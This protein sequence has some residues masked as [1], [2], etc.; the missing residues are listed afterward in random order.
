VVAVVKQIS[1][2]RLFATLGNKG[3]IYHRDQGRGLPRRRLDHLGVEQ[4][5][6]KG[7]C[8]RSSVRFL[9]QGAVAAQIREVHLATGNQDRGEQHRQHFDLRSSNNSHFLP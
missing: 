9:T 6:V 2:K 3:G 4:G 8:E 5:I 1:P 7:F